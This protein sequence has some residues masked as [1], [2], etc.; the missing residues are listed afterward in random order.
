MAA[1]GVGP[2]PAGMVLRRIAPLQQELALGVSHQGRDRAVLESAA[3][4]VELARGADRDVAGIDQDDVVVVVGG[5]HPSDFPPNLS[6]IEVHSTWPAR[7]VAE[8]GL[9]AAGIAASSVA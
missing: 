5:G 9:A 1:A 8:I 4:R 6:L 3:V 2:Q 7:D